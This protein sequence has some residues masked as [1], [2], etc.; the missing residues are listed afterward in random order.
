MNKLSKLQK[1][2][3]SNQK[4]NIG[5]THYYNVIYAIRKKFTDFDYFLM[6]F[7]KYPRSIEFEKELEKI[8]DRLNER[9]AKEP[10]V[11]C[12]CSECGKDYE[13][14]SKDDFCPRCGHHPE[15]TEALKLLEFMK[16]DDE[17]IKEVKK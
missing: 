15:Q 3:L 14:N 4:M 2:Y 16:R 17:K 9:L 5:K 8:S 12:Y 10:F 13:V 6:E 7:L 11:I 1:Q